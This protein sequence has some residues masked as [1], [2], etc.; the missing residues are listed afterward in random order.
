MP[1]SRASGSPPGP[2]A[3]ARAGSRSGLRLEATLVAGLLLCAIAIAIAIGSETVE[4]RA[5]TATLLALA[6]A[7]PIGVG[8]YARERD[9]TRRFGSLLIL[10]GVAVSLAA[11]ANASSPEL[12]AAGRMIGWVVEL[13]V[14]YALLAYPEGRLTDRSE[15]R[16]FGF[17]VALVAFAYLPSPLLGAEFPNPSQWSGCVERC[18][19]NPLSLLA[20]APPLI[21]ALVGVRGVLTTILYLAVAALL[22]RRVAQASPLA[23]T[24]LTPVLTVA[25]VRFLA[26]SVF[27]T[28]RGAGVSDDVLYTFVYAVAA[29]VPLV[30]IGFLVGLLRWRLR[31]AQTLERITGGV[32]SLGRASPLEDLLAVALDDP[33]LRLFLRGDR[34]WIRLGTGDQQEPRAAPGR[35]LVSVDVDGG[36]EA[37]LC[38]DEAV[39]DHPALV[40]AARGAV[41]ATLEHERLSSALRAALE[42]TAASRARLAAAADEE[43]ER[44]ERDLHD[45]LQQRLIGLRIRADLAETALSR[46]PAK[47]E[48]AV[49]RIATEAEAAIADLRSLARGIYPA[50]LTAAGPAAALRDLGAVLPVRIEV[51]EHDFGRHR[52]PVEAAVYFCCA[53]AIQNAVKHAGAALVRIDLVEGEQE[54]RFT[55][56]DDGHW[57]EPAESVGT[58]IAGMHDRIAAVGGEVRVRGGAEGTVV[59]G[60][61]PLSG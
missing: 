12:F 1:E 15:R 26:A 6:I 4:H 14:I 38:V 3:A 24:S 21:D 59:E 35:F 27:L 13:L 58:G 49:S 22:A 29:T 53:E 39:R 20:E 44:I 54:L 46:D 7:L 32:E 40:A 61:I 55:V 10:I 2:A 47:A 45:G 33:D 34:G 8:A 51:R 36:G 11:L 52:A 18:P 16:V 17:A 50:A 9:S 30:T 25:V 23:R 31:T 5:A 42:E 19:E 48:G 37:A 41:R 28:L 43:R 57:V 56:A 60:R